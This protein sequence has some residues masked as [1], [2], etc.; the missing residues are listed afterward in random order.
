MSNKDQHSDSNSELSHSGPGSNPAKV[1]KKV[2]SI[3]EQIELLNLHKSKDA[4]MDWTMLSKEQGDE[5]IK[6]MSKNEDNAFAYANKRLDTIKEIEVKR[7]DTSII[8]QKT[9]KIAVIMALIFVTGLTVLFLFFKPEF[10]IPW[11]TFIAGLL[12]GS[13][14]PRFTRF[15]MSTPEKANISDSDIA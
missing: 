13:S 9:F 15:I 6:L 3:L 8:N 1:E 12:G 14:I 5:M 10:L 4:H 7:L 11:F 2:V